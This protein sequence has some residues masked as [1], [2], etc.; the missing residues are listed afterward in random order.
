MMS[1]DVLIVRRHSVTNPPPA[2]VLYHAKPQSR[3]NRRRS[4]PYLNSIV[5]RPV[6]NVVAKGRGCAVPFML[7]AWCGL[8]RGS[9]L[10]S[11]KK[12]H[13][14]GVGGNLLRDVGCIP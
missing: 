5:H 10:L 6:V 4:N 3:Q 12:L 2:K 9:D 1:P 13:G 11:D 8:N 14:V 7:S